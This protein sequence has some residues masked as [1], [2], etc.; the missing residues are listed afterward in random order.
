MKEDL[1]TIFSYYKDSYEYAPVIKNDTLENVSIR[2][3]VVVNEE[4]IAIQNV[5]KDE[6]DMFKFETEEDE[7]IPNGDKLSND[8]FFKQLMESV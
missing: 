7:C 5:S 2:E 3:D 4:E 6:G 8:D 1:K